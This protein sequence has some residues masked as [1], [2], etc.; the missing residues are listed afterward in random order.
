[1]L[2]VSDADLPAGEGQRVGSD[3]SASVNAVAFPALPS[4][5]KSASSGNHCAAL[6]NLR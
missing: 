3:T 1:M 4:D 6:N 5:T 2:Y